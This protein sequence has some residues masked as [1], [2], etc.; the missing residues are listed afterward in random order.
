MK[1]LA[2]EVPEVD[3]A[4]FSKGPPSSCLPPRWDQ[5]LGQRALERGQGG[6][7][8]PTPWATPLGTSGSEPRAKFPPPPAFRLCP[9]EPQRPRAKRPQLPGLSTD[10]G[11]GQAPALLPLRPPRPPLQSL[12][13]SRGPRGAPA[14]ASCAP[15]GVTPVIWGWN[16][17]GPEVLPLASLLTP[18]L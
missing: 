3:A 15:M 2:H 16:T 4:P 8:I 6:E 14:G 10:S 5:D 13:A 17:L 1:G 12:P 18:S 11:L 7:G 9:Q